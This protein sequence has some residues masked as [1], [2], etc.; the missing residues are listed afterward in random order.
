MLPVSLNDRLNLIFLSCGVILESE[1]DSG[2][3]NEKDSTR[4]VRTKDIDR[5]P[6]LS[7]M[8]NAGHNVTSLAKACDVEPSMISR[9]L[10]EPVNNDPDESARNPS[11]GLAAKISKELNTSPEGLFPDI[12]DVTRNSLRAKKSTRN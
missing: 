3:E 5:N 1:E 7:A 6:L 11:I 4:F 10:R 2:G 12:F 9:L 8:K